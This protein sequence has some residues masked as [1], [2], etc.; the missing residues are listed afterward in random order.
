MAWPFGMADDPTNGT[1]SL[2]EPF[3]HTWSCG[4][5]TQ[6]NQP[7][8]LMLHFSP[9]AA[10]AGQAGWWDADA[11]LRRAPLRRAQTREGGRLLEGKES[12]LCCRARFLCGCDGFV[13]NLGLLSDLAARAP[14]VFH[15]LAW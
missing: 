11:P 10:A 13:L 8:L 6:H 5:Q 1:A 7:P 9:A 2:N 4:T 3:L 12:V 14:C 15:V